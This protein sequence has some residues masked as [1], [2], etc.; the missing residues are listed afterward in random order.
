M[1]VRILALYRSFQIVRGI[2]SYNVHLN[3]QDDAPN[4]HRNGN[5]RK[6]DACKFGALDVNVFPRKNVTPKETS[7]RCAEGGT[8]GT[9]VNTDCHA[10]H[11]APE[12]S[13]GK[14]NPILCVDFLP[15]LE[16]TA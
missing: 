9:I 12:S 13:V 4:R 14:R 8:K 11:C 15:G 10:V 2:V 6:I 16:H 5:D 3:D 7:E 1:Y